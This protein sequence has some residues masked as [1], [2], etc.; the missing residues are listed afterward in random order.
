MRGEGS[1]RSIPFVLRLGNFF[2]LFLI[3]FCS[4]L[5]PRK[6]WKEEEEEVEEEKEEKEKEEEKED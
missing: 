5:L 4:S 3:S 1:E 6:R 2:S